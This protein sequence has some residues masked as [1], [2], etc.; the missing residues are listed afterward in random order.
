M[1]KLPFV[2][3]RSSDRP[4]AILTGATTGAICEITPFGY[5]R[6]WVKS[7]NGVEE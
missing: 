1:C 5:D 7:R 6:P 2:L 3:P 4:I